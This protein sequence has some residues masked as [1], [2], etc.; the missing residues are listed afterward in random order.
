MA[1]RS[2]SLF[3]RGVRAFF[4]EAVTY[5]LAN[6][7]HQDPLLK[8]TSFVNFPSRLDADQLQVEYFVSRLDCM[9]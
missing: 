4:E 9:R 8:S 7:P 3:Y 2:I 1:E 6:L 5:C